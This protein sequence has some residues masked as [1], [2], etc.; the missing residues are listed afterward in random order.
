MRKLCKIST[1]GNVT[2]IICLIIAALFGFAAYVIDIGL[3][4]ADRIK[5]SNALDS[6]VLAAVLELPNDTIKATN[7]ANLYLQ[8]NNVDPKTANITIGNNNH[9][10]QI[11]AVQNIKHFFAPLIGINS[12]NVN[13]NT[14]AIIGPVKSVS[15]GIRPFAVASY[16]FS[17]GSVVTL[18]Q[19]GGAGYHG[20]YGIV[21]LGG[22]GSSVY[23]NNGLHGYNGKI[24]VGDWIDTEPGNK[25]GAT[26]QIQ[27]YINS[28]YSSFDNFPRD[29]IRLWTLPLVNT[30][31]V[32]GRMPILVT[33]FGEF[34]VES[35][36]DVSGDL[37][38]TG[39]FI[40][41]VMKGDIDMT[42]ADTGLYGAKLSN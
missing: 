29:S 9:S 30:L 20:N 40:K 2:I 7:M 16:N 3:V 14:K 5:L 34:Y 1:K 39:R 12:S 17:Y 38:I 36:Q 6:A 26:K 27:N 25:S 19:G 41:Y 23:L 11:S 21:A 33:G 35:A 13:S 37:E 18:K 42:L 22:T 4:Y 32:N 15:G 31:T 10:I 8:S 28:E 24:S